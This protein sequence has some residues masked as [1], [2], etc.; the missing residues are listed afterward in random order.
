M[1]RQTFLKRDYIKDIHILQANRNVLY[2]IFDINR[3]T[4]VPFSLTL[5]GIS[6][7]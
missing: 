5:C 3:V 6:I 7:M 2:I 1:F 4:V